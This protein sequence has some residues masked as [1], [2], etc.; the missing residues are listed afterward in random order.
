MHQFCASWTPSGG[1]VF[2]S[3]E[4]FLVVQR[5]GKGLRRLPFSTAGD[6]CP[7]VSPEGTTVAFMRFR[8]DDDGFF[9]GSLYVAP[10]DGGTASRVFSEGDTDGYEPFE[11]VP[12]WS[13]D[14]R[15]IAILDR[16]SI[17]VAT[18]DGAS[19]AI[20]T[21]P[22]QAPGARARKAIS[23]R[24]GVVAWSPDGRS[25]AFSKQCRIAVVSA[26]GGSVRY[27]TKE[28][29]RTCDIVPAWQPLRRQPQPLR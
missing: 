10:F 7:R 24:D 15:R 13:P 6:Q 22:L 29:P 17:K 16:D 20:A 19:S 11:V 25:I 23:T 2:E 5:N 3:S 27:V 1:L 8:Q 18:L 26:T 28:R 21:G 4:G 9:M 14:G 12:E